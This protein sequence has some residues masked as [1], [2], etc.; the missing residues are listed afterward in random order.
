MCS[1]VGKW[2]IIVQKDSD[3]GLCVA[4]NCPSGEFKLA[5]EALGVEGC[6]VPENKTSLRRLSKAGGLRERSFC[7]DFSPLGA[8]LI[9]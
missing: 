3:L 1:E 9:P 2:E 4:E 6:E 5:T 7:S 8:L